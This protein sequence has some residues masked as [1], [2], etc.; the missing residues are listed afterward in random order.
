MAVAKPVKGEKNYKEKLA[1]YNHWRAMLKI[2]AQKRYK[3][4]AETTT[5]Q[6]EPNTQAAGV[7]TPPVE[8]SVIDIKGVSFVVKFGGYDF[9]VRRAANGAYRFAIQD[10]F[11]EVTI[12]GNRQ[13]LKAIAKCLLKAIEV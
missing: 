6:T 3:K 2:A 9:T 4:P 1:K 12:Q 7:Y 11:A 10:D 8:E 13:Y 5:T